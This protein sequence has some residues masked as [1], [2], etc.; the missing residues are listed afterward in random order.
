MD[1]L[2]EVDSRAFIDSSLTADDAVG[3]DAEI[4][5]VLVEEDYDPGVIVDLL[6]DE[7]WDVRFGGGGAKRKPESFQ[8]K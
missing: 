3:K 6:R 2:D 4:L 8:T 5:V 1:I 7:D